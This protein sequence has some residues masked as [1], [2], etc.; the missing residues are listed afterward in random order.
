MRLFPA[1]TICSL[2]LL[3]LPA[4]A[5][6]YRSKVLITP[7]GAL[8]RGSEMSIEELEKQISSIKQPYAK[9]SAGRHLARHYVQQGEY[10]RAVAYYR[11]ALAAQGLSD[12]ANREMLRELAQVYLLKEDYAAAA[13]TLDRV[14]A[15]DLVPEVTDYLLLAQTRYRLRKY[16]AVV[17]ALDQIEEKG[18]KMDRE[19][20]RQ[21]LALYYQAG[22]YSQSE[23]LLKELLE[24]EPNNAD[25]W[26][27]LVSVYLQQNK[28][29]KALDQL[30]LARKKGI[31]FAQ[32]D[33]VLL[34]DLHAV[35][36]NPYG[37]GEVLSAALEAGDVGASG[38]NYRKLFEFWFQAREQDKAQRALAKAAR[39]T[40]DTEL[41]LYL[42]QLQ[43]DQ[44]AWQPMHQTMLSA[45]SVTLPDRHVGRANLL[46]GVSQLKLGDEEGARRS[47][48]NATLIGGANVQA[49]QWLD[50]MNA[51]PATEREARRI[52]G[53]C[54]GEQD[55]R[56]DVEDVAIAP[57]GEAG[58]GENTD[59]GGAA[60]FPVKT[61]KPL[62]LYYREFDDGLAQL[63]Q[64]MQSV[65]PRMGVSLIKSGGAVDGPLH[66]I[67]PA[68]EEGVFQLALPARGA[69]RRGGQFKVRSTDQFKCAYL[70]YE[71]PPAGLLD[72]WV[73]F[74]AA[75]EA[76]GFELSGER[77][78]LFPSDGS[79]SDSIRA[80]LQFG[81]N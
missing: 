39:L 74:G 2:L 29:R 70:E 13:R 47:F 58:Q 60:D 6:Q 65:A 69:P 53:I 8:S 1:M 16:V 3:A 38:A 45:C 25:N 61:V 18:L 55:K 9:S 14:L 52:V 40:G 42:A 31:P 73:E 62:R 78:A 57:T 21:A 30:S 20:M 11:S 50:F 81:V 77:R 44:R 51:A 43:M 76:S 79:S 72:A 35:N 37:A 28:R 10:D 75:L 46:L 54:H 15:L 4:Q 22:A 19:Q 49:G 56:L 67:A 24:L 36:K 34:A 59:P 32:R 68:G 5:Q 26:H 63:A 17:A 23:R 12:I 33:I 41:Y 66:I 64:S 48:I 27:Q 7:D 71:G 80:E